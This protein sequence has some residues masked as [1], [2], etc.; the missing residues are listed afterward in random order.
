[1]TIAFF[2]SAFYPHV[3]GVEELCRQLAHQLRSRG[4][5]VIVITNR[6]P[7]SLPAFEMFEGIPVYSL[8]LRA[9][10]GSF[11]SWLSQFVT[12]G[13]IRRRVYSI[14]R[15]HRAEIIHIH[16]V[17]LNA[18]Y[19]LAARRELG[20][21]MIVTSHGELSMDARGVFQ[22]ERWAQDVLRESLIEA[23]YIT[24]PS[25]QTLGELESWFGQSL[26]QKGEVIPN[27][28]SLDVPEVAREIHSRPYLLAIGRHVP[29]KGFDLL[30]RAIAELENRGMAF[31]DLLLAG[32]GPERARLRALS[33][34]LGLRERVQFLGRV[35]HDRALALFGGCLLFILPSRHE[36]FG[37]VNL[38]AM[39]AGKAVVASSVGGV[40]E[41]VVDGVTGLLVPAEN[42]LALAGAIEDLVTDT[43]R[44][45]HMGAAGRQR[46][47]GHFGWP[48][49]VNRYLD[50]YKRVSEDCRGF[51]SPAIANS[52]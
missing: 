42:V 33:E 46:V 13:T 32:D 21:P 18:I 14:L 27:G 40:P 4:H 3:G 29:Q 28:I 19:A 1:M 49:V 5:T 34:E 48:A 15:K 36:P 43:P 7:R 23:D 6:W 41:I 24:A 37:L 47:E 2:A 16:C 22:H 50:V 51:V 10:V 26:R 52:P 17:S 44:C 12:G 38:E 8:A 35:T 45:Q 11:K 25:E 30:L 31:F 9:N 20:L 39:A